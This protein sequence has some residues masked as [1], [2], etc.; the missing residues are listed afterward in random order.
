MQVKSLICTSH[1]DVHW[2]D[3]SELLL[4]EINWDVDFLILLLSY[5]LIFWLFLENLVSR[6]SL[7][8]CSCNIKFFW[9]FKKP[10]FCVSLYSSVSDSWRLLLWGEDFVRASLLPVWPLLDGYSKLVRGERLNEDTQSRHVFLLLELRIS[11][12]IV[13]LFC[14]DLGCSKVLITITLHYHHS[15]MR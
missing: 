1:A 5:I 10:F 2:M 4:E 3:R 6:K 14:G 8:I 13:L 15:Y 11:R 12:S 9:V 7:F